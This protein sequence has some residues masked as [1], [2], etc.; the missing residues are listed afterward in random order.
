VT[1][2]QVGLPL[3][4]PYHYAATSAKRLN[5]VEKP[6]ASGAGYEGWGRRGGVCM[7]KNHEEKECINSLI[8]ALER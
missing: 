6:A 8:L 5:E 3:L 4:Y 7:N 2:I 1:A